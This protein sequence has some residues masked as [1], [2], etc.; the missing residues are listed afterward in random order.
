[1]VKIIIKDKTEIDMFY[2]IYSLFYTFFQMI[3]PLDQIEQR[4]KAWDAKNPDHDEVMLK[5]NLYNISTGLI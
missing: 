3:V 2:V 1:M 4:T 5:F